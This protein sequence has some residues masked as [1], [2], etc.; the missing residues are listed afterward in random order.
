MR[1]ENLI[2]FKETLQEEL[3]D[4]S[5]AVEFLN[6]ALEEGDWKHFGVCLGHVIKAH[7]SVS[8]LAKEIG[9]SRQTIYSCLAG[10]AHMRVEFLRLFAKNT[11]MRLKLELV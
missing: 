4:A 3:L 6:G 1:T 7:G 2:D 8:S 10:S 5:F 11:G 9:I